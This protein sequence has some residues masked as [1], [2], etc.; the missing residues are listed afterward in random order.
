MAQESSLFRTLDGQDRALIK[1]DVLICDGSGPVALAGVMGGENSE[2]SAATK[3]VALESAF[4]D[5]LL[6]RR[7]AR[8]LDLRSEASSRFEKGIDIENVDFAARRA[9]ELMQRT[10]GGTVLAGSLEAYEK[11]K[12]R[13]IALSLKRTRDLIGT[14]LSR[15]EVV[16]GLASI[17]IKLEGGHP[18]EREE[19]EGVS[20]QPLSSDAESAL[21]LRAVIPPRFERVRRPHRGGGPHSRLR[22]SARLRPGQ[23]PSPRIAHEDRQGHRCGQ[24]VPGSGWV[25]RGHQSSGGAAESASPDSFNILPLSPFTR[26]LTMNE[27]LQ[28]LLKQLRLSG[29][30]QTLDVRLQEAAGDQLN[31]AEFLELILQDELLVRNQRLIDRRVK[32][33]Q[34]RELKALD[35]FDWSFN[36]SIPRKQIFDLA[37]CR[38]VRE[39]ATCLLGPPG[40][41]KLL[42]P[43]HRYLAIKQGLVVLYRSIFDVVRD[44]LHDEAAE[45]QEK[46]LANYLKPDLLIVDDMGMKQLPKRRANCCSRSSCD[47]TKP[48][49]DDDQQPA[50]GRLGQADRRRSQRHGNPRPLPAPRGNRYDYREELSAS[51]QIGGWFRERIP[52][53]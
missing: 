48:A 23:P 11:Q 17:G 22:R 28:T 10:A 45:G 16:D 51:Q 30:A 25:L 4:F 21:L 37:T 8:R 20:P 29:L 52:D 33:A 26:S 24:D 3:D 14:P 40:T 12:P 6:I 41:G 46:I 36:P 35:D 53:S 43:G 49:H 32:A 19:A 44:F 9:I 38:F 1:G 31:H 34:F 7:T 27:R 50:A 39:T 5:P 13:T 47:V 42:G 2:I 18:S 15:E